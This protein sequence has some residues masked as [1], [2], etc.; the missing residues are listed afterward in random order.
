MPTGTPKSKIRENARMA[1]THALIQLGIDQNQPIDIFKI[2]QDAGI[3]LMFQPLKNL[4]GAYVPQEN[5]VGIIIH[6]KHPL[7]L[8]RFTAAHEFAHYTLNH[9]LTF[10]DEGMIKRGGDSFDLRE[11]AADT[12]A[13]NFL[14]PLQLVNTMLVRM[15]LTRNPGQLTA[16]QVYQLSLDMGVSYAAAINQLVFLK[17]IS[18]ALGEQL[19]K[20]PPKTIKT[21]IAGTPLENSWADIWPLD[22]KSTGKRLNLRVY[23]E[24]SIS[25][26]E[27]PS[28]GYIWTIED[29]DIANTPNQQASLGVYN[30]AVSQGS[31]FD[32]SENEMAQPLSTA[33]LALM[34]SEFELNVAP[35][36]QT[37]FGSAGN[38]YMRFRSLR[39]GQYT[40][41]L[42]KH[43]PWQMTSPPLEVFEVSLNVTPKTQ[44]VSAQQ[45]KSLADAA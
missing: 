6:S 20:Q 36:G 11:V 9:P 16:L 44:G 15:G 26:P 8:Q 31:L 2:I 39:P 24:L 45:Q 41:R 18:S 7:S 13:A 40:L 25:L 23:D 3:W 1:A 10:D 14:M 5:A 33:P 35:E 32:V 29:A 21:L 27:T 19:R 22:E 4:Y 30:D 42:L 37:R 34:S 28:T 38:R 17:K 12:F 43:R